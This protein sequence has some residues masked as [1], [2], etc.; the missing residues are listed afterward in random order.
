MSVVDFWVVKN[1]SGRYLVGLRWWSNLDENG[2][3]KWTFESFDKE[4]TVNKIDYAFFWYGQA[5]NTLFWALLSV[6]K[7]LTLSLF[8]VS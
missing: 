2:K 8:W 1:L 6:L 7:I 3:E 5:F 4:I